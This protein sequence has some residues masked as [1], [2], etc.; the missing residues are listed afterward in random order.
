MFILREIFKTKEPKPYKIQDQERKIGRIGIVARNLSDLRKKAVEKL[1]IAKGEKIRVVLEEDGS[2]VNDESYFEKLPEQTAFV[3]LRPGQFWDGYITYLQLAT[4]KILENITPSAAI[5]HTVESLRNDPESAEMI[6]II[7]Y[8]KDRQANVKAETINEDP[9]WFEDAPASLT[10]KEAVLKRSA[11]E[12]VRS[13]FHSSKDFINN[14]GVSQTTRKFLLNKLNEFKSDLKAVNYFEDY[15]ARS[16]E[17]GL[18]FCNKLGWF[19]C[20]GPFN[21]KVCTGLHRI[22]PYGSRDARILFKTWNLDHQIEKKREVLPAMVK[23][24]MECPDGEEINSDYFYDLLFTRKNLKLVD[25]RCHVI[26]S[27]DS[28]KVDSERVYRKR[29][30]E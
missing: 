22:N 10:T 4:K 30:L 21:K 9:D 11:K 28:C 5:L 25:V 14:A 29:K 18:R 3:I 2:E 20:E 1:S 6:A 19:D 15:F 27:H 16:A 8:V 17:T 26:S 12:R 23:A 13:Y 7:N 24:A